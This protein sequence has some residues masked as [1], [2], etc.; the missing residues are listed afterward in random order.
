MHI[1]VINSGGAGRKVPA[2]TVAA[3]ILGAFR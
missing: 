3:V 2:V 1:L